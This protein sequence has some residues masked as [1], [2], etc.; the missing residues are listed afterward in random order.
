MK[1]ILSFALTL[2]LLLSLAACGGNDATAAT[3][4]LRRA[5]GTVSVSDGDG[6]DV[7]V[8]D[9][10]GLY[11]GDGVGTQSASYAWIDLDDVKL[12]KMDQSSKI[13]I[14]KQGK[15]LEIEVKSGSLFFNVTEPMEDD[16]TMNIRTTTMLVGIRGTSGWVE[17]RSGLSRVYILEGKVEC[18]AGEQTVLVNAGEFAELTADGEL[19]VEQ[20][21]EGDLPAFVRDE[22]D[23]ELPDIPDETPAPTPTPTPDPTEAPASTDTPEPAP[24][25]TPTPTPEPTP[26]P[27][28]TPAPT[29]APQ[30]VTW[31]LDN[32]T[33]TISGTGPMEDYSLDNPAPW[34]E[35]RDSIAKV[36]IENGVTSI[37]NRAFNHCSS[38]T[39]VS[40]PDSV[41]SIG[42]L[43]FCKCS[44]LTGVTIPN[45]VTSIEYG[46]FS[47]CTS[48]ASVTIPNSVTSIGTAA[49][50]TC[51]SLISVTI[52][53][54]VTSIGFTAFRGCTS[55][56]SITIPSS[57]TSIGRYAFSDC[58]N[59]T[60]VYYGGSAGQWEQITIENDHNRNDYLLN[61][62][63]H[64]NS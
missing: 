40:I 60:N 53:N 10:L 59:L 33:L 17:E 4:H 58:S 29:Q 55:L 43:S 28:P 31:T 35:N 39:D 8:L 26:T 32:G 30:G 64:Y 49:F 50:E 22:V 42:Q 11:S 18:S 15:A 41:T 25:T 12:A 37:G 3:M 38:L 51:S 9:N 21:D 46:V 19:V 54:S 52:P 61:A 23:P 16:E 5:E 56:T 27:T 24:E 1:R 47:G 45:S 34:Y 57:V 20:F 2:S 6:K 13:T 14:Q 36:V 62:A 44:S 63:I 48:L 7:P